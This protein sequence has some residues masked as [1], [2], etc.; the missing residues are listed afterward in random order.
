MIVIANY[1]YYLNLM[2]LSVL[3]PIKWTWKDNTSIFKADPI[4]SHK[5]RLKG[6]KFQVNK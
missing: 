3:K 2:T 6:K 5:E 1:P 4:V